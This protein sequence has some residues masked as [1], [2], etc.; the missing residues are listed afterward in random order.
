MSDETIIALAAVVVSGFVGI[1][2]LGFNFWNSSRERQHRLAEREQEN[3]EWYKRT[4]FERRMTAAQEAYSWWARLN[5]AVARA[6]S[7]QDRNSPENQAVRE[8]AV[9]AR[10]WYDNNSLYL[11]GPG[12]SAFVGLTNTA[13]DWAGGAR[14]I[15]IHKSLNEVHDWVG[16]LMDRLFHTEEPRDH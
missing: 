7:S 1:A 10:R 13:L 4:L 5:E 15:G 12:P 11:E 16:K 9:Q 3:R 6:S 14:D 2:S 8:L